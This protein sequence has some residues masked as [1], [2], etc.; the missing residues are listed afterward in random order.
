MY[1]I[2]VFVLTLSVCLSACVA[3]L[4]IC[5]R[6]PIH[7][8]A[9]KSKGDNG[10]QISLLEL[11]S[12]KNEKF[13]SSQNYTV[14]LTN[15]YEDEDNGFLGFMIVAVSDKAK[16]ERTTVG[17]F[18]LPRTGKARKNPECNHTVIT[19]YYLIEKKEVSFVWQAPEPGTGCVEFRGTVI[20][21]HPDIWFKD[22]GGLTYKVCEDVPIQAPLG[23]ATAQGGT[24][25][26][27]APQCCA[28]GE[29]RYKMHFQGLWSRQTHPKGFPIDDVQKVQL[30]WSS[31]I[32]ASHTNDYTVWNYGEYA[33]RGVKEVCEYGF[34]NFLETEFK[35]NSKSIKSVLKTTPLWGEDNL[36]GTVTAKFQVDTSKHLFSLL[37]MIG[38]S[39]DWC[40][41]VN[42]VDLCQQNCTWA[43]SMTIDLYPW[44][45]GTDSGISYFDDNIETNPPEKIQHI[46]NRKPNHPGSP[47]FSKHP[48]KPMA[49]VTLTKTKDICNGDGKE[50]DTQDETMSTSE[51]I[52]LMK[53]KMMMKKKIAICQ[54]SPSVGPCRGNFPRWYYNT[55]LN[56]CMVFP[57]GG[58]R[59]NDNKFENEADCNK[60][61]TENMALFNSRNEV[62]TPMEGDIKVTTIKTKNI[63]KSNKRKRGKGSKRGKNKKKKNR[64]RKKNGKKK[65]KRKS[66]KPRP[67][68]EPH[69]PSLGPA[70]DCM[71]SAWSDWGQCSVTCGRG[72]MTKTRTIKVPADNGG[73]RCPRK[74]VKTR[75]CKLSKCP[76]DC[77][78]GEWGAW[79]PCSQT[80]GDN[81][82]QKRRRAIIKRPKRGG[83]ICPARRAKRMCVLPKC[84]DSDMERM[85]RDAVYKIP[86]F[87]P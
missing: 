64:R 73:Q 81:A 27:P 35:R 46:T 65:G 14:Q 26:E 70:I 42:K 33:S 41:G 53:K 59:G 30:H 6:N 87:L 86:G 58:C 75:K 21:E 10:F 69:D 38:P 18:F 11:D 77:Q 74:L 8:T 67:P 37:S 28:C 60:Y 3:E 17:K 22:E 56:T 24:Q 9:E 63:N 47:F 12:K 13:K 52:K 15:R 32:G 31:V 71:V 49:R 20:S 5:E 84:P 44:D 39:P 7:T 76:V 4:T 50:T 34:S 68:V 48:I 78:M 57:Y 36:Q 66:L 51:L 23:D 29:A 82:V 16:D 80:C 43:D 40:V 2:G 62:V 19:H 45:A 72:V 25:V 54:L 61:C 85:M 79:T 83:Q 55:T 1:R